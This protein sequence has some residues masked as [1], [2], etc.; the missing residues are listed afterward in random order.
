MTNGLFSDH[1]KLPGIGDVQCSG[2]ESELLQCAHNSSPASSCQETDDAGV[3]CQGTVLPY[4]TQNH[5]I[6]LHLRI[7]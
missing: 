4:S 2:T 5:I 7:Y 6:M 1:S 3:V